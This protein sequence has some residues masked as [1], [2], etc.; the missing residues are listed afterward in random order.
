[1]RPLCLVCDTA[2]EVRWGRELM[3]P[4]CLAPRAKLHVRLQIS[5]CRGPCPS[6]LV[7]R[8][9]QQGG[10]VPCPM[11]ELSLA[12]SVVLCPMGE[13]GG[14]V[15]C[16]MGEQGGSVLRRGAVSPRVPCPM[17]EAPS[18]QRTG[19]CG[20]VCDTRFEVRRPSRQ[21]DG[22]SSFPIS[23]RGGGAESGSAE[24]L[25]PTSNP[26]LPWAS[27]S[28]L[29]GSKAASCSVLWGSK[30][31]LSYGGA[32]RLCLFGAVTVVWAATCSVYLAP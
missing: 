11:G 21:C 23:L 5:F 30:A 32:R 31:A 14:S 29:W 1:M 4:L 17:A 16:P 20:V 8:G 6:C 9:E 7:R 25:S 12:L 13:Q 18:W 2:F 26:V 15:L 27:C 3:R 28:V 19:S 10:F 24:A 22:R